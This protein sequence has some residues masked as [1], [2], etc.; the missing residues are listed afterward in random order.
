MFSSL[1]VCS[2]SIPD[3]TPGKA[4]RSAAR[5]I[6]PLPL[7]EPPPPIPVH[8]PEPPSRDRSAPQGRP[9]TRPARPTVAGPPRLGSCRSKSPGRAE[10]AD[11]EGGYEVSA[12]DIGGIVDPR[13]RYVKYCQDQQCRRGPDRRA[14]GRPPQ[15]AHEQTGERPV[16]AQ[17]KQGVP[18]RKAE[19][20]RHDPKKCL[21]PSSADGVFEAVLSSTIAPATMASVIA[22]RRRPP[23]GTTERRRLKTL[24]HRDRAGRVTLHARNVTKSDAHR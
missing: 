3:P 16:E 24:Y 10:H 11:P 15:P 13:G 2:G 20:F 5:S 14:S 9:W 21:G 18:A 8:R 6:R 17:R 23:R 19:R 4:T 7:T 22:S 1:C 12:D